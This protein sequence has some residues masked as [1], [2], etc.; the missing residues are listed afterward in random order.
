MKYYFVTWKIYNGVAGDCFEERLYDNDYTQARAHAQIYFNGLS[1]HDKQ[2]SECYL[3]EVPN[4]FDIYEDC[5]EAYATKYER[6][7]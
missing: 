6:I 3:V 5:L 7:S 2:H 4:S 1:K